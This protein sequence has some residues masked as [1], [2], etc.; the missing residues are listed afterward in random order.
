[1]E[2]KFINNIFSLVLAVSLALIV[3]LP[4]DPLDK[5]LLVIIDAIFVSYIC[6]LSPW[7]QSKMMGVKLKLEKP[8]RLAKLKKEE[9]EEPKIEE[10]N[11]ADIPIEE[12]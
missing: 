1:M 5:A 3:I 12:E 9:I 6:L 10:I 7:S 4:I 11:L 8:K 2:N